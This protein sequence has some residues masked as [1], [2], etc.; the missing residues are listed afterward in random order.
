[1]ERYWFSSVLMCIVKD[2]GI[3]QVMY[4]MISS[5]S[6]IMW[7]I[8]HAHA[9]IYKYALSP[10]IMEYSNVNIHRIYERWILNIRC[11]SFVFALSSFTNGASA[12]HGEGCVSPVSHWHTRQRSTGNEYILIRISQSK[13]K[14]KKN[15][16]NSSLEALPQAQ[17][18]ESGH[19]LYMGNLKGH[20]NA[21]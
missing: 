8:F 7:W 2:N 17:F 6:M 13:Q 10:L 16:W 1:M 3:I 4:I 20:N 9:H 21:E 18:S 5:I 14:H 15:V 12:I 11:K 19:E